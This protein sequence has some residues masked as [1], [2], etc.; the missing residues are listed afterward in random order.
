MILIEL[1][2]FYTDCFLLQNNKQGIVA[3]PLL[4]LNPCNRFYL[5]GLL[6]EKL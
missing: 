4:D 1:Y 6:K 2:A 3:F 5:W